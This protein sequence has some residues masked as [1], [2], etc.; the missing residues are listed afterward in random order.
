MKI[1]QYPLNKIVIP[2]N[3]QRRSFDEGALNELEQSIR[4]DGLHEPLV[5]RIE[6]NGDVVLVAGER[7][8]R[9]LKRIYGDDSGEVVYCVDKGQLSP[10]VR[11]R[12]ELEENT[13]R[14]D[15]SWQDRAAALAR[16]H[17]LRV[18]EEGEKGITHTRADTAK[19]VFGYAGGGSEKVKDAIVLQQ[20]KD[21]PEVASAK[22][23]TE[24][25]NAVR[26]LMAAEFSTL[27]ASRVKTDTTPHKLFH[28]DSRKLLTEWEPNQYDVILTDP[29]FGIDAHKMAPL[30]GSEAATTHEYE[31][32]LE[33]AMTVWATIFMEGFR[34]CKADAALY[35]FYDFRHDNT[36]RK[37]AKVAGWTVWPTPIIWHKPSG[38]MIGD[39]LHGPRKSYECI[40]FAYKGEKR[41]TGMF[42][43]VIIENPAGS[44]MHGAAKPASLY[45][46]LLKRSCIPGMHVLDMCC[47]SGP[48]FPAANSLLLR[49]TGIEGVEKH[50]NTSKT[51]LTEQL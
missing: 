17:A 19:E 44:S 42:L 45:A 22:T 9:C 7:R 26:K 28:G 5:T 38:G 2:E 4:L 18:A 33:Y 14:E 34:V 47:G 51:R 50:Y 11:E 27:L 39:S 15:L 32:T 16:L 29:P 30:S 48:I 24:A 46:N 40:L 37:M 3:R 6:T 23:E 1:I 12:V 13:H 36:I 21:K 43:D 35:F 25:M 20:F 41:T 31:D 8:Y 10:L 49:A